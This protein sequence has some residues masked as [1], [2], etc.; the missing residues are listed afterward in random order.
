[1]AILFSK[2][3]FQ[4]KETRLEAF[5]KGPCSNDVVGIKTTCFQEG[6]FKRDKAVGKKEG[7]PSTKGEGRFSSQI[8]RQKRWIF[9]YK[10]KGKRGFS[11]PPKA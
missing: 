5:D 6:H 2:T 1:M 4:I 8:Q 10:K 7:K 11:N 9:K 3:S